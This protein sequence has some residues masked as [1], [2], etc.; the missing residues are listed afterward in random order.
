MQLSIDSDA[1]YLVVLGAKSRY[2]GQYY[3]QSHPYQLNY[4]NAPRNAAIH[5][6]CKVLKN[7]VCSAV[8]AECGVLFHNAQMTIESGERLK[9]LDIHNLLRASR[10]TIK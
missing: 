7:I 5:T 9:Y 3:L 2:A 1:A 8:E 10:W 6:K 4:N